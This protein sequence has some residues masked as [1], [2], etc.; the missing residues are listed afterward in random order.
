MSKRKRLSIETYKKLFDLYKNGYSIEGALERLNIAYSPR[1][2]INEH[3]RYKEHGAD[4]LLPPFN[5]LTVTNK[6]IGTPIII[7]TTNKKV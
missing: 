3:H 7:D 4:V 5:T 1:I 6:N 2:L